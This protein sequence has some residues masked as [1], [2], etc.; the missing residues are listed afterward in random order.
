MVRVSTT[1][2]GILVVEKESVFH[3]IAHLV[4][5]G[6]LP[7]LIIVTVRSRVCVTRWTLI[8]Q[9]L[10][11][12]ACGMP[13]IATRTFLAHIV[14]ATDL[15]VLLLVDWDP[16]GLLIATVYR[17]GSSVCYPGTAWYMLV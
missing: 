14:E 10:G 15:P 7:G 9:M 6:T 1:A 11:I 17:F 4:Q 12:Q 2:K 13:D 3:S 8:A 5:N 16:H